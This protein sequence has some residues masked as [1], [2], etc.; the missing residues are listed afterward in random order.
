MET[1]AEVVDD[2]VTLLRVRENVERARRRV[3][4]AKRR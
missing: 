1:P 4:E 3:E 2:L